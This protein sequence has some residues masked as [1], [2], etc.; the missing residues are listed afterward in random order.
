MLILSGICCKQKINM[1]FKKLNLGSYVLES[2]FSLKYLNIYLVPLIP[3]YFSGKCIIRTVMK[4]KKETIKEGRTH[5][6]VK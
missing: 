5:L 2:I 4:M 6:E 1:S 3:S